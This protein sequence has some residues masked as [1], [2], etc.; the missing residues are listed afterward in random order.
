[1]A[2]PERMAVVETKVE[3]LE[4]TV[5]RHSDALIQAQL[6]DAEQKTNWRLAIAV[7]GLVGSVFVGIVLLI[8]TRALG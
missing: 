6:T 3:R 5:E 1:M 4:G 2:M 8:A 7:G